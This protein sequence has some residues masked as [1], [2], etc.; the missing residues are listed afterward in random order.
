MRG[1]EHTNHQFVI[2]QSNIYSHKCCVSVW[3]A[4]TCPFMAILTVKEMKSVKSL[5]SQFGLKKKKTTAIIHWRGQ[6]DDSS[7]LLLSVHQGLLLWLTLYRPE[8]EGGACESSGNSLMC[9]LPPSCLHSLTD[10][11]NSEHMRGHTRYE[12]RLSSQLRSH[13]PV[14]EIKQQGVSWSKCQRC[15][16][17]HGIMICKIK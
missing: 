12:Q 2:I 14:C 5:F 11:E 1:H 17:G 16:C 15:A 6:T 7:V 3:N 10:G 13:C 4:L 8:D 9:L